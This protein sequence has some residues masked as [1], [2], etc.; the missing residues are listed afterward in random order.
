MDERRSHEIIAAYGKHQKQ[1][2]RG[3]LK[4]Y[5]FQARVLKS[6]LDEL[7][8][9]RFLMRVEVEYCPACGDAALSPNARDACWNCAEQR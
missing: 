5:L 9:G 4:P 1:D 2:P 6:E 3:P 7:G 8:I